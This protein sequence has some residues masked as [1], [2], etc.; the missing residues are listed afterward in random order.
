MQ[1]AVLN[2]QV[3]L[4]AD[5]T[6]IFASGNTPDEA[7]RKLQPALNVFSHWCHVNKLSINTGK[8]KLM[9]FGTRHKVKKAKRV[10]LSLEGAPLQIVPTYKYLGFT[11]DSTLSFN[12]Q[13]K[14]IANMVAYKASLLAR[15]RKFLNED[16][17]LKIYKSMIL[18]YFDYGDVIYMSANQEGLDKLQ[19]LQ[20]RCLKICNN[21]NVRF[22]TRELHMIT[23]VPKLKFR[24][25]AHLNNFMHGRLNR[26]DLVDHR[27]IRTRLHDAP[28]FLTKVPNLEAYK[29][30]V[31][32]A[33][34]VAWNNLPPDI[35]RIESAAIFKNKQK[36][37][38]L[39]KI[40]Q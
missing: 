24:R 23:K 29:R 18:P 11:L 40:N 22:E 27:D 30:A 32:F 4:Y 7:V 36:D 28:M 19:R 9:V 8:T 34:A 13:V 5:D 33:G 38:L 16:V 3:Q 37:T 6:V 31:E 10:R 1:H 20:N 2:A 25:E 17:A 15:I 26:L 12:Y 35:R 14:C 39:R 21:L